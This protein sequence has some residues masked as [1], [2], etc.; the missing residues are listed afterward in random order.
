MEMVKLKMRTIY[1]SFLSFIGFLLLIVVALGIT[2]L[3]YD[4]VLENESDIEV[5][6]S[7]SINYI[8]GKKINVLD[9]DTISFSIT[10]SGTKKEYYNI[11][12]LQVRGNGKYILKYNNSIISEGELKS[13]DE[14]TT[15]YLDIEKG[16]T[17]IYTLEITNDNENN[18]TAL[19]N[20]RDKEGSIV[21]FANTILNNSSVSENALTKVGEE[22]AIEDEGLIKNYD[23]TNVSY[24]FRGNVKNNYVSF[25]GFTW[26]I[27]RINGDGTVRLVLDGVTDSLTTYYNS[28]NTSYSYNDSELEKHL[29]EW[30]MLYLNDYSDYIANSKFCNDI[31]FDQ[32]YNYNSYVRIITNKIPSLNCLGSSLTNNIGTLAIDEVVLAGASPNSQNLHYYLHNES[33]NNLWY[34]LSGAKGNDSSLNLFMIDQNGNIKT[35]V[36][37]NLYRNVRPV[38]NLIKN[39]EVTGDGTINNP[40]KIS[41]LTNK[42]TKKN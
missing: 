29:Q 4:K 34:T 15:E 14:I 35:D 22:A 41:E 19:L 24:Y 23:D 25:A 27:V 28:I 32:S 18:L 9:N 39:I 37:G 38:I 2:Y 30:F 21:T 33:I 26:R 3:F 10:N 5:T 13:I 12:F 42:T 20:I 36:N 8:D 17:K 6:G 7:L 31:T 11:G 40:Y 16:E 1:K